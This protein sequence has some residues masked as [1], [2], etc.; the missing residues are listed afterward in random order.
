MEALNDLKHQGKTVLFSA[1]N[2]SQQR[3]MEAKEY[4]EKNGLA[5]FSVASNQYSLAIQYDE[6]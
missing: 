5:G 1:S 4:A 2:W 6:P 3:L